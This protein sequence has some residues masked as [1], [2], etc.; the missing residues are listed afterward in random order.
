MLERQLHKDKESGV[1]PPPI[2]S[3]EEA[4]NDLFDID[5]VG[6]STFGIRETENPRR[7]NSWA[8]DNYEPPPEIQALSTNDRIRIFEARREEALRALESPRVLPARLV[9]SA[10]KRIATYLRDPLLESVA[11]ERLRQ[12]E[13]YYPLRI[14]KDGTFRSI[15]GKVLMDEV[16]IKPLESAK[17]WADFTNRGG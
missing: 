14:P 7:H 15:G 11:N 9:T 2:D 3:V 13:T 17:L 12:D 5:V 16:G 10:L 1:D 4:L 6:A 8:D